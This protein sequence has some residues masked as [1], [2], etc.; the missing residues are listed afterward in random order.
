MPAATSSVSSFTRSQSISGAVAKQNTSFSKAE[1][2]PF[3]N[4]GSTTQRK[5]TEQFLIP[6]PIANTGG[7]IRIPT[8]HQ[9]NNPLTVKPSLQSS[10]QTS[11]RN[12][13]N[14]G[15]KHQLSSMNIDEG[16]LVQSMLA[17]KTDLLKIYLKVKAGWPQ[18]TMY[19]NRERLPL[20]HVAISKVIAL[21]LF[22][23][24]AS[25]GS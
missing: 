10:Q 13:N 16:V 18:A 3:F 7:G 12:H 25:R 2:S 5:Q 17:G 11:S 19:L 8:H 23:V 9:R 21:Y 4:M 6:P 15:S 22:S 14:G 20:M 1:R 24:P